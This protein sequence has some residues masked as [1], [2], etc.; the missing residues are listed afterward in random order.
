L[1]VTVKLIVKERFR[2]VPDGAVY[3]VWYEVGSTVEGLLAAVAKQNGWTEDSRPT[4]Q[5]AKPHRKAA[6]A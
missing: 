1:E 3:P 6:R 4:K 2:G 5:A